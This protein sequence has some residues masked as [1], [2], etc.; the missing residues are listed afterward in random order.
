MNNNKIA[1]KSAFTSFILLKS[2]S[3]FAKNFKTVSRIHRYKTN[4]RTVTGPE[5]IERVH[6]NSFEP[7][8]GKKKFQA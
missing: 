7:Q 4:G 8:L 3:R 5:N 6:K 2:R 1:L